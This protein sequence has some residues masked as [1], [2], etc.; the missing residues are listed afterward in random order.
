MEPLKFIETTSSDA[1]DHF[2]VFGNRDE[3]DLIVWPRKFSSNNIL[4]RIICKTFAVVNFPDMILF[5]YD[6]SDCRKDLPIFASKTESLKEDDLF[7]YYVTRRAMNTIL[8][9]GKDLFKI[10]KT[11][12]P[13]LFKIGPMLK[14]VFLRPAISQV[15]R[16]H[17]SIHGDEDCGKSAAL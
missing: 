14:T 16:K 13:I 9:N 10:Y 15:L 1:K 3:S 6:D 2:L 5:D 17:Q 11:I 7:C 8:E 12:N 4:K